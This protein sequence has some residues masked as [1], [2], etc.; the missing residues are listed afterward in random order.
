MGAKVKDAMRAPVEHIHPNAEL[1]DAAADMSSKKIGC[2]PVI[3]TGE[4]VGIL[5]VTD[6]LGNVAQYPVPRPRNDLRAQDLMSHEPSTVEVDDLLVDAAAKMNERGVRHLCVVDGDL[7]PVG[8]LSDRDIRTQIG[9]LVVADGEVPQG[10]RLSTL[11]VAH[12][13]TEGVRVAV[14]DTSLADLVNI[15]LVEHIGAVP[16]VDGENRVEGVVS[17]LDVLRAMA[18][19]VAE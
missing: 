2:L 8:M 13:M 11:R 14:L 3:E 1:A 7:H 9:N 19:G 5:T 6:V 16:V 17:Y 18:A 4:L 15:F 12:A 10:A